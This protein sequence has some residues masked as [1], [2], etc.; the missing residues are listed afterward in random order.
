MGGVCFWVFGVLL[1][2]VQ[3]G[4]R[5]LNGRLV[6]G[7]P[8]TIQEHPFQVSVIYIDTHRC[9]GSI[10]KSNYVL[11]AAHCTNNVPAHH[12]FVRAG[13]T[14]V[15]KGKQLIQVEKYYQHEN[16]DPNTYDY[17]ISI[18]KLEKGLKFGDGVAVAVLPPQS[19]D[20][21]P[22]GI[23]GTVTGWGRLSLYGIRPLELNEVDLP[24]LSPRD[25]R[26]E[27]NDT[28]TKRMFCAGY[29]KGGKD[30]CQGDSGGPFVSDGVLI[31]VTSWGDGCGAPDN[32]GVYAKVSY[33]R[34]YIDN[35]TNS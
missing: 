13:S 23:V 34:K 25:C 18:L 28:V 3:A 24:T 16:F 19:E 21:I 22:G 7:R 10:L 32:P 12:L 5:T 2:G 30:A 35:I 31:G 15:D 4:K 1:A 26:R 14:L 29:L 27:Y 11:T 17:D 33:F 8:T 9:G 20:D 6:G